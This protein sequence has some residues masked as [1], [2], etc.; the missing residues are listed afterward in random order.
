MENKNKSIEEQVDSFNVLKNL[1]KIRNK[2]TNIADAFSDSIINYP[3]PG[4]DG[5]GGAAGCSSPVKVEDEE[6]IKKKK[7]KNRL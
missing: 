3:V 7:K 2:K 6:E 1:D 4:G 5:K